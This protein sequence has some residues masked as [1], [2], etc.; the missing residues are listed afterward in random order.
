MVII[1][2]TIK[3]L[4]NMYVKTLFIID[5]FGSGIEKVLADKC[6]FSVIVL[7][8]P[9]I[10]MTATLGLLFGIP[11]GKWVLPVALLL[12]IIAVFLIHRAEKLPKLLTSLLIFLL[13][14]G[15]VALFSSQFFDTGFDTRG[16]HAEAILALLDGAN[17]WHEAQSWVSLAYPAAHWVSSA[18]LIVWTQSFEASFS[19]TYISAFLALFT[20]WRFL[21]ALPNLT[22]F[23]RITLALL[24]A[25]NPITI[26]FFFA[27][28]VDGYLVSVLLSS[29]MLMLMFFTEKDKQQRHN[30]SIYIVMLLILLVNIKFTGLVYGGVLGIT[31]LVYGFANKAKLK[32][33]LHLAGLGV[34]AG[35]LGTMLFGF[36]PYVTN[37]L[38]DNNPFASVYTYSPKY[39][40][41]VSVVS[42]LLEKEFNEKTR[43]EKAWI[44]LFSQ[45]TK[46][47]WYKPEPLPPFSSIAP[48]GFFFSFGA[49]FSGALLLCLTLVFFIRDKFAWIILGGILCSIFATEVAFDFRLTPQYWWLPIFLLAF[50]CAR[51]RKKESKSIESPQ[52]MAICIFICIFWVAIY[53]GKTEL[54]KQFWY[55]HAI[56]N[57]LQQEGWYITPDKTL[58]KTQYIKFFNYYLSGLTNVK[59]PMLEFCPPDARL[60]RVFPG[61]VF[62]RLSE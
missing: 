19:L 52:I 6:F 3:N 13:L 33:I 49:I 18:S 15:L 39:G 20:C 62:C 32:S 54:N 50:F 58:T 59:L 47:K 38:A 22:K 9:I 30:Y 1:S 10:Y 16:Y 21:A 24:F 57:I 60:K 4:V 23:W 51:E 44:A 37:T 7:S 55:T 25:L 35:V 40:K 41:K 11:I 12:L 56:E 5:R 28:Y 2:N 43:Y 48:R 61:L 26:D 27:G 14:F 8:L 53:K 29:F 17:P 34:T 36:F 31:A 42:N 46:G 45:S